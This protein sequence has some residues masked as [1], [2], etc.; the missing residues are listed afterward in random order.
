[1]FELP[2]YVIVCHRI[3]SST[4]RRPPLCTDTETFSRLHPRSYLQSGRTRQ[5]GVQC[6]SHQGTGHVTSGRSLVQQTLLATAVIPMGF[7]TF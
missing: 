7:R 1:L 2:S 5:V 4:L 6:V 3:P